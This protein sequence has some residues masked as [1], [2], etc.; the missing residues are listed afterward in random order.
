MPTLGKV[1][2]IIL[3]P[4]YDV[5]DRLTLDFL[6]FVSRI[7]GLTGNQ[8]ELRMWWTRCFF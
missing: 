8:K 5:Y 4:T 1:P 7:Q 2:R 3:S 6:L